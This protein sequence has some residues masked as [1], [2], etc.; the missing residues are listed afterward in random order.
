[1][2]STKRDNGNKIIFMK[3]DPTPYVKYFRE[4]KPRTHKEGYVGVY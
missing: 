2:G 4:N 1:M 3:F